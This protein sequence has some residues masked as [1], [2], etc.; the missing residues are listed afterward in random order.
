MQGRQVQAFWGW[1]GLGV[2]FSDFLYSVLLCVV[3]CFVAEPAIRSVAFSVPS[4]FFM[5]LE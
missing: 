2:S 1:G 5:F 3:E 4:G